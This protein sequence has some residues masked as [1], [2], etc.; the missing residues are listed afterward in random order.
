MPL[1]VRRDL[2][3]G[4]ECLLKKVGTRAPALLGHGRDGGLAD[5]FPRSSSLIGGLLCESPPQVEEVDVGDAA[6]PR[7]ICSGLAK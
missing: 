4:W 3:R 5:V 2:C 6:G 1:L 7:T